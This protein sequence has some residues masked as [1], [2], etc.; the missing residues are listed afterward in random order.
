MPLAESPAPVP[1]VVGCQPTPRTGWCHRRGQKAVYRRMGSALA[2][3]L[4]DARDMCCGQG[5]FTITLRGA[6]AL[7]VGHIKG[8]IESL[9][10]R[11]E[12]KVVKLKPPS[13]VRASFIW[14]L[15]NARRATCFSSLDSAQQKTGSYRLLS[16]GQPS[17]R[18]RYQLVSVATTINRHGRCLFQGASF[19]PGVRW[20]LLDAFVLAASRLRRL[21]NYGGIAM[22]RE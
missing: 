11:R 14:D 1:E 3:A 18:R 20:W 22:R 10:L 8:T 5:T 7:H 15:T 19:L 4:T 13:S 17:F 16:G 12:S 6:A 21:E 2:L 9:R